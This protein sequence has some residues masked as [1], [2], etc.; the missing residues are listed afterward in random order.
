MPEV[1][2]QIPLMR[3]QVALTRGMARAHH[4]LWGTYYEPWGGKPF[5]C[6][7]YK[8]D[9]DNEWGV[10]GAKSAWCDGGF[11]PN[12]GSSRALQKRVYFHSLLS[13]A[14][15]LSEEWGNSNVFYDWKDY[16]L[17]PYG[18][19]KR[20]F[21]RFAAQHR[22]LGDVYTPIALVLPS[23]FSWF[24]LSY[25]SGNDDDYLGYPLTDASQKK[26][27]RH[28]RNILSLL[29]GNGKR[30]LGNEGHVIGNSAFPDV[31]DIVY[32]TA[33]ESVL[34]KYE[35]WIDLSPDDV[36]HAS[37]P[38]HSAHILSSRDPD[39]LVETL[40]RLLTELLPCEIVS[41]EVSWI[42]NRL[43]QNRWVVGLFNNEGVDRTVEHGD[44]FL[45][46]ANTTV[47]VQTDRHTLRPLSGD[48]PKIHADGSRF[49]FELPAGSVEL[50]ELS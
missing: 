46:E 33:G 28:I 48:A 47:I 18:T 5:G 26:R 37:Y 41:G 25:L 45:P 50:F 36:L 32:D 29:L 31:F 17:T 9:F 12:S 22:E 30:L 40:R 39:F 27:F 13:G 24:D 19:I 6:A 3:W 21:L 8:Q 16:E 49:V 43:D 23:E 38:Q 35:Y 34:S 15:F 20:D 14:Q 2:A 4:A 11:T 42:L 1:G 10:S 7:Y 44:V